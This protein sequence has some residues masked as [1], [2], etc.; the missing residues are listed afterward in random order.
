MTP[1]GLSRL[2]LTDGISVCPIQ[3]ILKHSIVT[4]RV[5][6][7]VLNRFDDEPDRTIGEYELSST[8]MQAGKADRTVGVTNRR[9]NRIDFN[10]PVADL[11]L[12]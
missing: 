1:Q 4:S 9:G 8:L 12:E 7:R 10:T 11:R 6:G 5:V 2:E 3:Q